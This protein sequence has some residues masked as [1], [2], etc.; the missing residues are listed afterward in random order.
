MNITQTAIEKNRVTFVLLFAALLAGIM[1]FQ[2]MPRAED[3]G[4]T[5]RTAMVLTYFPGASP[6][7]VETLITDKL[8]KSIQ[9]MPELDFINSES[10]SGVSIVF[11]N[12]EQSYKKMRPIWDSLRRKV[13]KAEGELPEGVIGPFVNDEFGDIF[14]TIITI[15][16]EGFS[17]AQLKEVA[18]EVRNEMLLIDDVAKVEIHGAQDERI[19]VEYNDA[20]LAEV[21][22]SASQLINILQSQNIVIP[23]GDVST[24]KEKIV[25]EPTGSFESV[26]DLKHTLIS[27]PGRTDL[28]Y[29]EDLAEVYRGYIDPPQSIV[30]SSGIPALALAINL[31]EKGN[32]IVLGEEVS[33]LMSRLQSLYPIGIEFD[34][35]AFQPE[36][37]D[38]AVSNFTNNLFQA[39][40]IVILVMLLTLGIR[41]GLVVASLVPMTMIMSLLIMSFLNIGLDQMSLVALIIALGLLVDNAIVMS[42]SIMVQIKAGV[43]AKEAA[44]SSATELR[45][46][47]LIGSLTTAAAFLPFYLAESNMGEYIGPLFKVVTITLLCSWFLSEAITPLF[48]VYFVKV[49]KKEEHYDSNFYVRYRHFL[50]RLLRHPVKSII[51]VVFIFF[52]AMQGFMFIPAIFF[53]R[54]DKAIYTADFELPKGTPIHQ[55]E[56]VVKDIEAF[57]Q[58]ELA[59]GPDRPEGIVNWSTYIGAG[60]PRFYIAY[61]PVPAKPEYATMLIN[62][63]SNTIIDSLIAKTEEYCMNKFPELRTRL[64]LLLYGP[65]TAAVEIRVSGK[66]L[67]KVFE[68]ADSVKAK[69]RTIPG[70]KNIRDDWGQRTKKI[71]VKINQAR[72]RRAGVTN[73]DIAISLQTA[74]TGIE[75]TQFREEDKTIPVTM[76]SE[77][78]ERQDIGKLETVN[79][80]AQMT[81]RNVP[82]KQVA[83]LEIQWQPSKILRRSRLKTVT[84]Q[85]EVLPGTLPIALSQELDKWL[86]VESQAWDVGY[87]YE[88]GGEIESSGEANASIGEKMPIGFLIIILLLVLQFNSIRLPIIVLT[89]IPL[90]I[91]G[92]VFGLLIANSYF[93]FMT[94]L[95]VVSLAGIVVNNAIVLLDRIKYEIKEHGW[96]PARAVVEASQRRLRPILLTTATTVGGLLPLWLGGGPMWKPMAIAIIFGLLFST[97]LTLGV[98]PV[99]Y[100]LFHKVKYKEFKF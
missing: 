93:G 46:P 59:A 73:R 4:F 61:S 72:A 24:G 8:E 95:G 55:M 5:I 57:M 99:L 9:E 17:Y 87:K 14:G 1:A 43:P 31:R 34:T 68:L 82:L 30:H 80:Y 85:S 60:A 100:S 28:I 56:A 13:E 39:I 19:F 33:E 35:V 3:P 42:E 63:T 64:D 52:I 62:T 7:R 96:E 45:V 37:V 25:L 71:L 21:G 18:D 51:A 89:T 40:A 10:R 36:H 47:L 65:P 88:L 11:V 94:L 70:T 44:I 6:E 12:I 97:M 76:R 32:I 27:I 22:L 16:G 77:G 38:R 79:V 81:G 86:K 78:A 91:I 49:K 26:E 66:E 58:R 69:L 54:N 29:V 74:L 23:G 2:G 53:P 92:V 41:T 84:V 83:D 98:V 48:C 75:V 50:L 15:T 67:G 90:G 20:R